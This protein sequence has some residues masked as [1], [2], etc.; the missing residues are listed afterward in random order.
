MKRKLSALLSIILCLAMCLGTFAWADEASPSPS[1]SPAPD[2][3]SAANGPEEVIYARLDASG[4]PQ[5]AYAIVALTLDEEGTVEHYGRYT[6]VSNLTD[7]S[8]IEYRG[9]VVSLSLIHI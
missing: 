5:D 7:T 8:P 3:G 9:G 6:A 1:A 4:D 2:S